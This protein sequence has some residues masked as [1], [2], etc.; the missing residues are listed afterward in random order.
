MA[1]LVYI[2]LSLRACQL[3]VFISSNRVGQKHAVAGM[4]Y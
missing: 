2:V 4:Y 1:K 3:L